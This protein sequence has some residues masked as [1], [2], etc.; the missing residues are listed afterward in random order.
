MRWLFVLPLDKESSIIQSMLMLWHT[1]SCYGIATNVFADVAE[2]LVTIFQ[3]RHHALQVAL[4]CCAYLRCAGLEH[5][6]ADGAQ[7]AALIGQLLQ[8][9]NDDDH[10][11]SNCVGNTAATCVDVNSLCLVMIAAAQQLASSGSSSSPSSSAASAAAAELCSEAIVRKFF[12]RSSASVDA[13]RV[14]SSAEIL[15]ALHAVP[16]LSLES[17]SLSRDL[18]I[19]DAVFTCRRLFPWLGLGERVPVCAL[20]RALQVTGARALSMRSIPSLK[21]TVIKGACLPPVYS[22]AVRALVSGI[23]CHSFSIPTIIHPA[24]VLGVFCSGTLDSLCLFE[25]VIT[26]ANWSGACGLRGSAAASVALWKTVFDDG[27]SPSAA[28]DDNLFMIS[29]A[30]S[31]MRTGGG[32]EPDAWQQAPAGSCSPLFLP[33]RFSLFAVL[34][35]LAVDAALPPLPAPYLP[36]MISNTSSHLVCM[37]NACL[38]VVFHAISTHEAHGGTRLQ[39]PLYTRTLGACLDAVIAMGRAAGGEG[40]AGRRSSLWQLE[41]CVHLLSCVPGVITAATA[42]GEVDDDKMI[43][44]CRVMEEWMCDDPACAA[45][46]WLL[47]MPTA[48]VSLS[49]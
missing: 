20:V 35:S 5:A 37:W 10:V 31:V 16:Q 41:S 19:L 23:A 9:V 14:M 11:A 17:L 42:S 12:A 2:K 43:A 27:T 45:L 30:A 46:V 33:T 15:L 13:A 28:A 44:V 47:A 18:F 25:R 4:L 29:A 36:W 22:I 38:A 8:G 1:C 48:G 39:M 40:S 7:V 34:D 26:S 24:C 21:R 32:G 49:L 3:A 6:S